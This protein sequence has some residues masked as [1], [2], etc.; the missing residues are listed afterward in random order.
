MDPLLVFGLVLIVGALGGWLARQVHLPSVTGNILGGVALGPYVPGIVLGPESV[1]SMMPLSNFAM[2]LIA[3]AIGSHLSWRRIH[4]ALKRILS[5]AL[6][7]VILAFA[8]VSCGMHFLFG[9]EWTMALLL[10]S[11]C[12]DSAPATIIHVIQ[13]NRAKGPFVK[14]LLST[15]AIDNILTVTIFV[16]LLTVV[17]DYY[18]NERLG[19]DLVSAAFH[20]GWILVGSL[21]L[22]LALGKITSLLVV[23]PTF[24]NF[25][26]VFI[27]ILLNTGLAESLGMSP[28]L[29]SLF[30]GVFL[31][32][33]T[34]EAEEQLDALKPIEIILYVTFFTL[35]GVTLHLSELKTIGLI[36]IA[37]VVLRMA[38]KGLGAAAGGLVAGA[39]RRIWQN[40]AFALMPQ[41][42]LAIALVILLQGRQEIPLEVRTQIST[43][44]L[45]A[46]VVNELIG[47][48]MTRFALR[49]AKEA[50]KDRPRLVEFLQEEFIRTNIEA[51]DKWEVIRQLCEFLIRTHRVE[52]I[53]PDKLFKS[54]MEREK[55]ESTAIGK[56]AA[57]PHGIV[58]EGPSIQG[59]L[60]ICPEGV[61]WEAPDG[62]PV[63]IVM[64]IVTPQDHRTQHLQVLAGLAAMISDEVIR[65]KLVTARDANEVWEI[66]ESEETPDYNYFLQD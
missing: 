1:Q 49:H 29:T 62:R 16:T 24:H 30:F 21:I 52:H 7:E 54:V 43:I 40:M 57:I 12:T 45:A 59:V 55:I 58:Q 34:R 26:T 17:G 64:L 41:A 35:A 61:E 37:F 31:A 27:A 46:V 8:L 5:I 28:L 19:I 25:T 42:G 48:L 47:P 33:S 9:L 15:V 13:E 2:G 6:G 11:L 3:V 22:G 50:N 18:S 44:V 10:A 53:H 39:S 4:N 20:T 63:R 51:E 23:H 56:G 66:I 36:G 38:G 60:G 14:T 32:N 65:S